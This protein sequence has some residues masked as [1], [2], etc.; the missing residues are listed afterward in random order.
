MATSGIWRIE[1]NAK[2]PRLAT[3][4]LCYFKIQDGAYDPRGLSTNKCCRCW[5]LETLS[6]EHQSSL[7]WLHR[8]FF[9]RCVAQWGIGEGTLSGTFPCTSTDDRYLGIIL[10]PPPVLVFLE[11]WWHSESENRYMASFSNP[12]PVLVRLVEMREYQQILLN[13]QFIFMRGQ[14]TA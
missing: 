13:I 8:W 12:L 6:R 14:R 3:D 2:T 7:A 11:L 5:P 10:L 1:K 9:V 4:I